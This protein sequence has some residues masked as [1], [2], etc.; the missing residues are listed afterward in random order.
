VFYGFLSA[1]NPDPMTYIQPNKNHSTLNI[2]LI[3]LGIG[4]FLGAVWLV[5]LYNNSVNFSHGLSEMKSEFQEVQTVNVE[6]KEKIFSVLD[7]LN[8]KSIA[9]SHNLVQEKKPQY[10]EIN[11]QWS[12]ASEF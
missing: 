10:L 8:S 6:L 3:F 5:I 2:L 11:T 9:A 1:S 4:F 12:Y 7:S